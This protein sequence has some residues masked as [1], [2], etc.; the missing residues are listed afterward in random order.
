MLLKTF[1]H[2]YFSLQIHVQGYLVSNLWAYIFISFIFMKD[3]KNF[4]TKISSILAKFIWEAPG[5]IQFLAQQGLIMHNGGKLYVLRFSFH[6]VLL[7]FRNWI[8]PFC[9]FENWLIITH[10]YHKWAVLYRKSG[11][12]WRQIWQS[13]ISWRLHCYDAYLYVF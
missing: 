11:N 13:K 12:W 1:K 10:L 6:L 2:L 9:F 8:K 3:V 5:P 4:W 7:W